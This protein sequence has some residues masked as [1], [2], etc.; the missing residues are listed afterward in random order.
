MK[1]YIQLLLVLLLSVANNVF[2]QSVN[3]PLNHQWNRLI[4]K[5]LNKLNQDVHTSFKPLIYQVVEENADMD[6]LYQ[7]FNK[8]TTPNLLGKTWW[9][10]TLLW[11]ERKLNRENLI[12]IKEKDVKININPLLDLA[13]GNI[14]GTKNGTFTNTRGFLIDGQIGKK[15]FFSSS[16]LESQARFLPY[17]NDYITEHNGVVPG[18]G[19]AKLFKDTVGYDFN[20]ASGLISFSPNKHFNFQFGHDRLF[21][22]DGY[23]SLLLSDNS[24][25]YPFL[26][27]TTKFWHIEY[28]N[29]FTQFQQVGFGGQ[30]DALLPKKYGNFHYLSWNVTKR[31]NVSL[32]E[33]IIS[34][35]SNNRMYEFQYLNPVIFLRPVEFANGSADNVLMGAT[36]K[37]KLSN[38]SYVYG[39]VI[40]D[41]FNFQ[42]LKKASG[43]WGNKFGF[44]LGVKAF[45]LFKIKNLNL[46]VEGNMVRPYTYS[47]YGDSAT[48]QYSSSTYTHYNMPLAH[49][50]GANFMEGL[51]FLNYHY[52]RIFLESRISYAVY[53]ADTANTNYGQNVNYSY[54]YNRAKISGDNGDFGHTIG[55]GLRNTLMYADFK[56]AYLVNPTTNLRVETGV[57]IRQQSNEITNSNL[58]YV[59]VGLRSALYN[60]YYDF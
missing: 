11:G 28:I 17:I 16:F 10:R 42:L 35:A 4:D 44:Q 50:L 26:K 58:T 60:Y 59:Y 48:A 1:T 46:Q 12:V 55:Q 34:A 6:S 53:G 2:S 40:I 15:F 8:E 7:Q 36:S 24:F 9:S 25:N 45:D 38:K 32:F 5:D 29:L 41:E 23:R 22:G 31:W 33:A 37:F 27:I 20:R 21:I 30:Q 52:K 3:F 14:Y 13:Y 39:Q 43:W 18:Q 57:M 54:N 47:H 49:P 56:A 19:R 51:L